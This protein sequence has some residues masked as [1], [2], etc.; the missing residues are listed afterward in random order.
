MPHRAAIIREGHRLLFFVPWVLLCR[1]YRA[2][3]ATSR[4]YPAHR[5]TRPAC[6]PIHPRLFP[7]DDNL[8]EFRPDRRR[9]FHRSGRLRS[10][11]RRGTSPC[12]RR[13][14]QTVRGLVQSRCIR[15]GRAVIRGLL[16][17]QRVATHGYTA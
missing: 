15:H 8:S 1:R 3:R 12:S 5:L 17:R 14:R 10:A 13:S 16:A 2:G 9:P 4:A 6:A 11:R 7:L